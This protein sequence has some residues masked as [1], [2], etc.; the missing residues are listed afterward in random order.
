MV[1]GGRIVGDVPASAATEEGLL[2]L[3]LAEPAAEVV[4]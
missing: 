3:A 2:A 1:R 4:A